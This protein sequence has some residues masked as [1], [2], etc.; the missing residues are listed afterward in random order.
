MFFVSFILGLPVRERE[1]ERETLN[2]SDVIQA[3]INH[4]IQRQ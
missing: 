4:M 2:I 3:G 1:R